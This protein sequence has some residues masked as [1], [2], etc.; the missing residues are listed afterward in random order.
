MK[1]IIVI[2]VLSAIALSFSPPVNADE[3]R[4]M[5]WHPKLNQ[6]DAEMM[7]NIEIFINYLNE[8]LRWDHIT[9]AIVQTPE[10]AAE[11]FNQHRPAI[12]LVDKKYWRRYK[13]T[14]LPG[15]IWLTASHLRRAP[16]PPDLFI[17]SE[18]IAPDVVSEVFLKGVRYKTYGGKEEGFDLL[19]F[20]GMRPSKAPNSSVPLTDEALVEEMMKVRHNLTTLFGLLPSRSS[21]AKSFVIR[22][23]KD[24]VE[25]DVIEDALL[26]MN[27]DP[28]GK[29]I[30][31]SLRIKRF[32]SSKR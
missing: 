7:G 32:K 5:I 19:G 8:R 30:L 4:M 18:Q 16:R 13:R 27:S 29:E 11:Y 31:E 15:R 6:R 28:V 25:N 14:I 26:N 2:L 17:G 23:S 3:V 1:R 24:I 10:Q 9:Y 21:G 12:G 22:F 20:M